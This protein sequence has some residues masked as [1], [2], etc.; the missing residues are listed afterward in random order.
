MLQNCP[1][2]TKYLFYIVFWLDVF[3]NIWVQTCAQKLYDH[4]TCTSK[5][6]FSGI[7][8]FPCNK[9]RR[10]IFCFAPVY[11]H[12]NRVKF[13]CPANLVFNVELFAFKV[14]CTYII[15]FTQKES[16]V[17]NIVI[18]HELQ[19]AIAISHEL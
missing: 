12:P 4:K 8:V 16:G 2:R 6:S 13:I 1:V 17:F 19:S 10:D 5:A 14:F 3:F 11:I 9:Y 18:S 15:E 7:F